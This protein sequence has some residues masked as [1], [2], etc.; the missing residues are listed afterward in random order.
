MNN[1]EAKAIVQAYFQNMLQKRKG[2]I[3]EDGTLSDERI[4]QVKL[5]LKD[6]EEWIELANGG[7]ELEE[8]DT[9]E[10]VN[11]AMTLDIAPSSSDADKIRTNY[12]LAYPAMLREVLR[13]NEEQKGFDFAPQKSPLLQNHSP[14]KKHTLDEISGKFVD[15]HMQDKRWD[16][17]TKKE[18]LSYLSV[19]QEILGEKFD[20]TTLDAEQ[21]RRVR[22]IVIRIPVNKNKNAKTRNLNLMAAI[23]VKGITQI[24]K[25]T[26]KKY[27]DC[28]KALFTWCLN[29]CYVERNPFQSIAGKTAPKKQ[30]DKRKAFTEE[31]IKIML[32][33]LDAREL[34]KKDYQYW[35][36][37][38]G[39]YTGARLNEV[40]QILLDDIKQEDGV[41]CFDMNDDEEGKKLKNEASRRRV[42]IHQALL[43]RG[44]IE[45]RDSL[46][47]KGKS[48]LL[49]E[50][51][52]CPKNGYG[53]NLG[54]FFNN[55]FLV[56]LNM[57]NKQSVFH[58]LRH[59]VVTRLTQAGHDEKKIKAII[60]HTQSGTAM[61]T[62]FAEGYKL[63]DLKTVVDTLYMQT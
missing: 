10:K 50:L 9:I 58:S 38:I 14:R 6:A 63:Q 39:I 3:I 32:K 57:K 55:Q 19:L 37:L 1:S 30:A 25:P 2:R 17:S 23:E 35:G 4:E 62:Y 53:K 59:T 40:A 49:Y 33:E 60:G 12:N 16:E 52:Y 56:G 27:L 51:T 20:I 42:P 29:E 34:A 61:T 11:L 41:W 54:R 21:A 47:K 24:S 44:I 5:V 46:K 7:A 48:R 43:D 13:F 36:T 45:Y 22:D 26:V 31:Q 18:K 28:Y 8:D 15:M